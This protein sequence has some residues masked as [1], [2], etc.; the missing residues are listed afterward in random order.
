MLVAEIMKNIYYRLYEK[1]QER[2]YDV[3]SEPVRVSKASKIWIT[4]K[5]FSGIKLLG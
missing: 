5:T 1:M 4:A 2:H 3:L